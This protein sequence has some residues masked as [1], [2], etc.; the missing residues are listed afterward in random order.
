[1]PFG[2]LGVASSPSGAGEDWVVYHLARQRQG[3]GGLFNPVA[4]QP[5]QTAGAGPGQFVVT[6]PSR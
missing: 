1:L 6:H 4:L 5:G 3:P 2:G